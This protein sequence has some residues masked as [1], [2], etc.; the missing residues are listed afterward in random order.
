MNKSI[1]ALT[2]LL[3]WTALPVVAQDVSAGVSTDLSAGVSAELPSDDVNANA[4]SNANANANAGGNS[5]N[6]YGSVVSAVSASADLDLN[7]YT[8]DAKVTIVLLSSLQG[9]AATEAEGLDNALSTNADAVTKLHANVEANA[10][11]KSKVEAAGYTVDD[12]VAVKTN[13]DGNLIVYVDD[14]A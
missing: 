2:A 9:N 11:I 1:L 4:N 13:V 8:D 3:S 7:V 6:T 14:R 12:V 5:D 10:V